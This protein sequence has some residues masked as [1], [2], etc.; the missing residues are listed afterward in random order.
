MDTQFMAGHSVYGLIHSLRSY[1]Q[2]TV[3]FVHGQWWNPVLR[4]KLWDT[5]EHMLKQVY[6]GTVNL[7]GSKAQQ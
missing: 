7:E 5:L 6:S 2:F 1:T 3:Q 4:E